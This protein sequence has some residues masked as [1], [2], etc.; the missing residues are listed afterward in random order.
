MIMDEFQRFRQLIN[1]DAESDAGRLTNAFLRTDK[2]K[3]LLLSA[4]PH[5]LYQTLE[6]SAQTGQDE[7]YREF[8]EV[9]DFLFDKGCKKQEF[10]E[11]WRSFSTALHEYSADDIKCTL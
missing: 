9:M 5:K 8:F 3:T 7:H 10:R 6:E 11:V 4:T 1:A 2:V